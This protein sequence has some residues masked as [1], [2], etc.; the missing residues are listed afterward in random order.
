[1]SE[2]RGSCCGGGDSEPSEM[3]ATEVA[4]CC[5]GGPEVDVVSTRQQAS[6]SDYWPLIVMVAVTMLGAA[7]KQ[8]HYGAGWDTMAW[9]AD[10]M[11]FFL[12]V[13]AMF[14]LFDLRGVAGFVAVLYPVPVGV[15]FI[16]VLLVAVFVE[17][18][19]GDRFRALA[20]TAAT[21]F[22]GVF[23]CKDSSIGHIPVVFMIDAVDIAGVRDT[24]KATGCLIQASSL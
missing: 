1:M 5:G 17:G 2:E 22:A 16:A 20:D 11:G 15:V 9:M 12:I 14:K 18:H 3:E 13:F 24:D 6:L 7:A 21:D 19:P 23:I 4:S 10:F 8:A